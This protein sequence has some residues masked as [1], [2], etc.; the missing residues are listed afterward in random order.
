MR[1]DA[2]GRPVSRHATGRC[3]TCGLEG[4]CPECL[5]TM[6]RDGCPDTMKHVCPNWSEFRAAPEEPYGGEP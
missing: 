3:R 2:C 5:A 6:T 1:C 4:L